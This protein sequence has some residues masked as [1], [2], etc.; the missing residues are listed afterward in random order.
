M[1]GWI[2]SHRVAKINALITTQIEARIEQAMLLRELKKAMAKRMVRGE[3]RKED[4]LY[5]RTKLEELK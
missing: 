1:S 5:I 2:N 4:L 3:L